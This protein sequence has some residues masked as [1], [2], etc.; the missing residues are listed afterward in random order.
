MA[1]DRVLHS[2]RMIFA[3][4]SE[5]S[6]RFALL[7]YVWW[8][9]VI[10]HDCRSVSSRHPGDLEVKQLSPACSKDRHLNQPCSL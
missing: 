9:A 5:P 4:V 6:L 10:G 8:T 1:E 3:G 2:E 7:S